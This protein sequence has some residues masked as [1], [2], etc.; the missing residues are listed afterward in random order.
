MK[1]MKNFL[2]YVALLS[3]VALIAG[4]TACSSGSNPPSASSDN[5]V[6][7]GITI[8]SA[9]ATSDA[10]LEE[11]PLKTAVTPN[12]SEATQGQSVGKNTTTKTKTS[13]YT[14]D[15]VQEKKFASLKG[16]TIHIT[17]SGK[18]PSDGQKKVMT[19]MQNK[20][21]VKF[22]TQILGW[23]ESQTKMGQMVAAGN[24]PDIGSFSE[25]LALRYIYA[26][27]AQPI[28]DYIVRDDEYAKQMRLEVYTINDKL[29]G[30]PAG[31]FQEY[32]LYYNKTL[33]KE[34]G[35]KD[36]YT[37][38]YLKDNWNYNTFLALCKSA[39]K[40]E[41]DGKT[42]KFAGV[43]TWNYAV[44]MMANGGTGICPDGKGGFE[45][46]IDK[47]AEM[48]GLQLLYDLVE[49]NALYTGDS[50]T[51]FRQRKNA[52]LIERPAHAIGQFDYYNR[53]DDE[54]GMVPLPKGPNVSQYHVPITCDGYFVPRNANNPL[55][56]AAFIYESAKQNLIEE[57]TTE[58]AALKKRRENISDEHL[59]IR[60]EYLKSA[61]P[62]YTHME[63]LAG[64][65]SG[66]R[67]KMWNQIVVDK[68]KPAEVVDSIKGILKSALKRTIG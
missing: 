39:T 5:S 42:L 47:P 4:L 24:P 26:N 61:V 31:Y 15:T 60:D 51:G 2:Q 49:A 48:A 13:A 56:G 57:H 6:S 54:I 67:D 14:L 22:E 11:E 33:F 53:M 19:T 62:V 32:Y 52:M 58:P 25:V 68:K 27:I 64:W 8:E 10:S 30:V 20:Y 21:G 41:A 9:D 63:G 12:T 7:T 44:F 28:D 55:G 46:V 29:Y 35:L 16:T 3:A 17:T 66:E 1:I 50:Y 59:A 37:E 43:G 38:Y 34:Y 23:E 36:P 40:Y 65:W 18:Q 45:V